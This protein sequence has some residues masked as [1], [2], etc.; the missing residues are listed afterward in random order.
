MIASVAVG[1]SMALLHFEYWSL[2]G[3]QLSTV[4]VTCSLAWWSSGWRPRL[5]RFRSNTRPLI[6]FGMQLIASTFVY[7][8][9]QA[10]DSLLLGKAWGPT[11]VGLYSRASALLLVPLQQFL[12]P[13]GTVLLPMLSRLR[14]DPVRY[15]RAFLQS[16]DAI[17]LVSFPLCALFLGAARPLVLVLL[18]P[19]WEAA[20]GL[21][22]GFSLAALYLPLAYSI[23]WLFTSQGRSKDILV[24]NVVTCS[25]TLISFLCG[26]PFGAM[27]M[28]IAYSISGLLVTLPVL[29]YSAGRSGP[30][31]T[32]D[33][34]KVFI[35]HSPVWAF[36]YGAT[37]AARWMTARSS[38]AYQLL[39]CIPIGLAAAVC[40][41]YVLPYQRNAAAFLVNAGKSTLINKWNRIKVGF[42]PGLVSRS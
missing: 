32:G 10:C 22:A 20:V 12:A 19:K 6:K 15:R 42:V 39:I 33:L 41:I 4:V 21:F 11:S 17:G 24:T 16:F 26:L 29:F 40:S 18:G 31:K 8:A 7:R 13:I 27:G 3:M 2:V 5:F 28:V 36:V 1:C 25:F 9:T 34:W 30:V 14:N 38:S 23:S 35:R 37:F